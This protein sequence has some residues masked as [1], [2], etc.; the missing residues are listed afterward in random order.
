MSEGDAVQLSIACTLLTRTAKEGITNRTSQ[1]IPPPRTPA[2]IASLSMRSE[3]LPAE[4]RL[5]QLRGTDRRFL[6]TGPGAKNFR[7]IVRCRG[8]WLV[9]KALVRSSASS[10][11]GRTIW[12]ILLDMARHSADLG[13]RSTIQ[14]SLALSAPASLN[15]IAVSDP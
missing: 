9:G 12:I 4:R 15:S 10:S 3:S 11:Y 5:P 6:G 14:R 13:L 8:G 2:Y 1:W 7:N